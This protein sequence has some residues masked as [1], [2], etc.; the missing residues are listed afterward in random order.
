MV[1][2]VDFAWPLWRFIV[3]VDG[4]GT[5]GDPVAHGNDL[6]RQNWISDIRISFRRFNHADVRYR[7]GYVS[8]E[9]LR[10]LQEAGRPL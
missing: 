10:G 5:H 7:P 1:A 3:E 4:F 8:Q 6:H 2:I 9:T